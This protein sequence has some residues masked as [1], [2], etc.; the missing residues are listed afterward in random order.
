[1]DINCKP[2][3]CGKCLVCT[4]KKGL[5]DQFMEENRKINEMVKLANRIQ[6]YKLN[7]NATIPTRNIATDA[8]ID[9]YSSVDMFLKKGTTNIIPTGIAINIPNGFVGK[10]E[11]R[12]SMAL[13]G[14]RTGA[15]VVDCGYSG[16]LSIILHNL[17]YDK[18][19]NFISESG[20]HVKKGDKIA[21]LLLY[22][23]ETPEVVEV[24][25]LWSSE[26]NSN[27]WGSSG[28]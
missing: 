5:D 13:K 9:I 15:G 17:T 6:T 11:D 8:G 10:I 18:D 25:E 27:G 22:K 4:F 24:N 23:I 3:T 26:R 16:E 7:E 12:S 21:Q 14:L 2:C 1:M 28:R 20:Y 19:H